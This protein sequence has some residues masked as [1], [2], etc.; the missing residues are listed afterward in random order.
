MK[1]FYFDVETTG[2]DPK[3]NS[4]Y[5]LSFIVEKDN[6]IICRGEINMQ[7]AE[8]DELPDDYVTPVGNITKA[9]LLTYQK[10]NEA[11]NS[12][13]SILNMYCDR[14]D[15]KDKFFIVGYNTQTF[16]IPFLR[17]F[18]SRNNNNYFGSYFWNH[19]FD[20]IVLALHYLRNERADMPDFKLETV[21]KQLEIRA[22]GQ[23]H[24]ANTDVRITRAIY[25]LVTAK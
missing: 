7:P 22:D 10:P 6:E 24:D 25:K 5:Q 2:L 19:S 21:A 12:M 8:I 16:D 9:Q 23:L 14:F 17:E 3:K 4:I 11:F 18:F 13:M 20:C 1:L 15:K